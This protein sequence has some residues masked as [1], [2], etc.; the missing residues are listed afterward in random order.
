MCNPYSFRSVI[1]QGFQG[2]TILIKIRKKWQ[3]LSEEWG[4]S[5]IRTRPMSKCFL[6]EIWIYQSTE[7]GRNPFWK[8]KSDLESIRYREKSETWKIFDHALLTG[9]SIF[10]L[11]SILTLACCF[12]L[13]SPNNS[14]MNYVNELIMSFRN[15][16]ESK[17]WTQIL[18]LKRGY[19]FEN[20]LFLIKFSHQGAP[21]AWR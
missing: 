15:H 9:K 7:P 18:P 14:S 17:S 2:I 6:E 4:D 12:L 3:E 16:L 19:Y 10:P 20:F 13:N 8:K 21:E 5:A 1:L 11:K